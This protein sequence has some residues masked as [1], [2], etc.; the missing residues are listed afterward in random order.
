MT[1]DDEPP[2]LRPPARWG[3]D[4]RLRC[5]RWAPALAGPSS[6]RAPAQA[7]SVVGSGSAAR[8]GRSSDPAPARRLR[9]R[10]GLRRRRL[11]RRVRLRRWRLASV[12]ASGSGAGGSA[13]GSGTGSVVG[14]RIPRGV[15]SGLCRDPRSALPVVPVAVPPPFPPCRSALATPSRWRTACWWAMPLPRCPPRRRAYPFF[16]ALASRPLTGSCAPP[17]APAAA[18]LPPPPDAA[19]PGAA[20]RGRRG[21][22]LAEPLLAA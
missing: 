16:L 12:P 15:A 4:Q 17:A 8:A 21:G 13:V 14:F 7:A 3:S 2:C 19:S 22:A 11:R 6:G 9:R 10:I 18:P 5:T 20:S 1:A